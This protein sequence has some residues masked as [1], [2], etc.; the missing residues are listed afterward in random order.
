[1]S[2]DSSRQPSEP[3]WAT[4]LPGRANA[5]APAHAVPA[6]AAPLAA[7][8]PASFQPLGG[9]PAAF[10]PAG[11]PIGYPTGL[12]YPPPVKKRNTALIVVLSVVGAFIGIAILVAIA[13]PVFLNQRKPDPVTLTMPTTLEGSAQITTAAAQQ[14]TST[15]VSEFSTDSAKYA[16]G[17]RAGLYGQGAGPAFLVSTGKLTRRP[18][19]TDRQTF[20][21]QFAKGA[22]QT[23]PISM[24]P[25]PPGPL[26]GT[27]DCGLADASGDESAVM[28]I[29]ID[30]SAIVFVAVYT[31]DLTQGTLLA[32][33][34]RSDVEHKK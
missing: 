7:G 19:A 14:V 5:P 21:S 8:P 33:Q 10:Q 24:V 31:S 2:D 29:S 28:C 12:A 25:V 20:V 3:T 16:T 27:T 22:Q 6:H 26:G 34:L 11:Y 23:T 18:T 1:M 15:M 17:F 30:N 9:P 4:I 13:I 32:T